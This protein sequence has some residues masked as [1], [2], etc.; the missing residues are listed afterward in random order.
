MQPTLICSSSMKEQR[1]PDLIDLFVSRP[2]SY[3]TH[4]GRLP[5]KISPFRTVKCQLVTKE[6]TNNMHQSEDITILS[7]ASL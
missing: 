5:L 1:V 2:I 7:M 4:D 3:I 6:I